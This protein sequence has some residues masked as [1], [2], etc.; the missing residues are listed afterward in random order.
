MT[1]IQVLKHRHLF[2]V[3]STGL[4]DDIEI[5]EQSPD[6]D[7]RRALVVLRG[8]G[9]TTTQPASRG[10]KVMLFPKQFD[11]SKSSVFF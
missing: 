4:N 10:S 5:D 2:R 6:E 3:S 11:V 8:E 7:E 1:F 9:A